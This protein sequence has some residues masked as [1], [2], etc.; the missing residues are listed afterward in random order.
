[1]P[2]LPLSGHLRG[3][4]F[5]GILVTAPVGITFYIAW[6]LISW[7]DSLVTP[8]L[9]DAYNPETYL[10]FALPGL[11]L[12]LAFV[13]LTFI[14]WATAGILGRLWLRL[15]EST[16]TRMPFLRGIYAAIK[17]VAETVLAQKS[18]AFREVVLL[19]YP[20]RDIWA[21]GFITGETR[22][23]VQDLTRT[24]VVNVFLPTTPNPTS[25]FLLFVPREDLVILDMSVEDG[26]KMVVSGGIITP[27][28]SAPEAS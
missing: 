1:M 20:R 5:A 23:E 2:Q 13:V 3:Y 26:L 19:E 11:G 7:I 25:G 17:Q 22:G 14:G 18:N 27:P 12:L 8:L 21:M 15:S 16:L 10:P 24:N 9:P 6:L 4:F 28:T